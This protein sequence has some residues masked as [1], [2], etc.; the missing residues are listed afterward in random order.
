MAII[1]APKET[2]VR[3]VDKTVSL[4]MEVWKELTSY[5][6]FAGIGGKP[7]DKVNYIVG[8]AL[9]NVFEKDSEYQTSLKK[10]VAKETDPTK[11]AAKTPEVKP[12]AVTTRK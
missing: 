1:K 8:E 6:K 10:E 9:K 5:A 12:A 4:D 7:A 11:S 3:I 2:K